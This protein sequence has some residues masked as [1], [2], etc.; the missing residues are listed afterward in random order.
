MIE[1]VISMLIYICLLALVVYLVIWV[2]E[3]V[4]IALPPK[5]IQII[6]IIVALV[7][8]LLLV[9][10]FLPGGHLRLLR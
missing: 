2:L 4:G 1:S 7:V 6:W 5:V 9:Q 3:V 8:I 10:T